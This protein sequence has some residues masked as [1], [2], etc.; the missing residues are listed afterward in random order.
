MLHI[1]HEYSSNEILSN[2]IKIS[3][4]VT[5]TMTIILKKLFWLFCHQGHSS[6]LLVLA[7]QWITL[8]VISSAFC[9]SVCLWLYP[10]TVTSLFI[11]YR[12]SLNKDLRIQYCNLSCHPFVEFCCLIPMLCIHA[13]ASY[14]N[15]AIIQSLS[16]TF[17]NLCWFYTNRNLFIGYTMMTSKLNLFTCA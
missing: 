2:E 8:S 5:W 10:F 15:I 9:L 16:Q 4:L 13:S 1:R 3:D 11:V 17:E 14:L 7:K 6:F 12:C